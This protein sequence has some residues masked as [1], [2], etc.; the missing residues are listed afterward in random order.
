MRSVS[1]I[2]VGCTKFGERWDVSL[3]DIV[4]EAGFSAIEDSESPAK[5]S[6]LYI[7]NM[8]AGRFIEQEHIRFPDRRLRRAGPAPRALHRV[9]AACASGGLALTPGSTGCSQRLYDIV[10]AAGVEKMTD[11]SGGTA[12]DA[13]ASAADGSGSASLAPPSRPFMP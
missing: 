10:I 4:A 8:S 13:L 3:R 9:E 12:A 7:G 2:G 6:A 5:I 1:I 11:V